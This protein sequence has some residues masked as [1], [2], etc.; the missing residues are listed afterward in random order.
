MI[1]GYSHRIHW[2][3]PLRSYDQPSIQRYV[4]VENGEILFPILHIVS[5][6][7]LHSGHISL[8]MPGHAYQSEPH[9]WP[10]NHSENDYQ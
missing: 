4:V 7:P 5:P 1:P 9:S 6:L 8:A 2:T 3:F 10:D